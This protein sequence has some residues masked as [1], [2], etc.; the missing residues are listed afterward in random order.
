MAVHIDDFI[1]DQARTNPQYAIAYAVLQLAAKQQETA[2]AV[3]NLDLAM[4]AE[5]I[6]V[7]LEAVADALRS[8]E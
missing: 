8:S 1:E 2:L 6:D 3:K 4:I 7:G 5:R